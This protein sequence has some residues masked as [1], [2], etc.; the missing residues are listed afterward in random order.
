MTFKDKQ[1]AFESPGSQLL[2]GNAAARRAAARPGHANPVAYT[3]CYLV[4]PRIPATQGALY[5]L[6]TNSLAA[7]RAAIYINGDAPDGG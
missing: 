3:R 5:R 4:R 6:Y 1:D 7:A 2:L